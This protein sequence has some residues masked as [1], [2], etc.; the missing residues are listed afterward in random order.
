V[1][2]DVD[3]LWRR[4]NTVIIRF[5]VI[6]FCRNILRMAQYGP[7]IAEL[8]RR[9]SYHVS[10]NKEYEVTKKIFVAPV[11]TSES[12]LTAAVVVSSGPPR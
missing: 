9:R 4:R 12:T 6:S 2:R 3:A 5:Y 10:R 11:L 8:H 1:P 7:A